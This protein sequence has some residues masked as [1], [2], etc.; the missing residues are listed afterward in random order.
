MPPEVTGPVRVPEPG[1]EPATGAAPDVA[2]AAA[3]PQASRSRQAQFFALVAAIACAFVVHVAAMAVTADRKLALQRYG[4]SLT[5]LMDSWH[6]LLEVTNTLPYREDRPQAALDEGLALFAAFRAK[7]DGFDQGPDQRLLDEPLR[8]DVSSL[9]SG[10]RYGN[11]FIEATYDD[12]G[13]FIAR[14]RA[15]GHDP[16]LASTMYDLLRNI[17][18]YQPSDLLYFFRTYQD[19]RKLGF[20]F[21]NQL[22][23]KQARIQGAIQGEIVRLTRIYNGIE[24][25]LLAFVGT[26]VAVLLWR[27]VILFRA[28]QQSERE[29][30][31][32]NATLE[33]R[34]ADRTAQLEQAN[35]ELEAFSYSVSHDLRAPLRHI[36]GFVELLERHAVANAD[37]QSRH[38]MTSVRQAA[39]RMGA[40]IDD[41]LS[42]SRLGRRELAVERVELAPLVR[43]VVQ[44]CAD[45]AAGRE[46]EWRIEPL[47]AVLA[48]RALLRVALVNLVGNA[49]KF[50]R[51]RP[52]AVIEV[53]QRPGA[54]G[55]AVIVVRDNGVGF[56]PTYVHKLFGV[57]QR[58]H[59]ASSFEG[60]GIGL[61]TVRRIV[62]RMGGR[63]W[64][65][66]QPDAGATF[67]LSLR[68]AGG[69]AAEAPRPGPA[70][71]AGARP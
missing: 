40:L 34:V 31:R 2:P 5:D 15:A 11:Q 25:V 8:Q 58:L 55:E 19:V 54:G 57:F 70:T 65:E 13:T 18:G 6:R 66:G 14:N 17:G 21:T 61:A 46:V 33:A 1:A 49:L 4:A 59:D 10:L 68:V 3:P 20:S 7:L 41:L 16:I 53:G 36:S 45:G 69:E 48:D 50:T 9:A 52:R 62:A 64:A 23:A 24:A 60:T 56:D 28:V 32:L 29:I 38:Y 67:Y 26:A 35:R 37:E 22:E 43:E 44:E 51:T 27:L 30:L 71:A 12:L 39:R 47:P 63:T 42:L